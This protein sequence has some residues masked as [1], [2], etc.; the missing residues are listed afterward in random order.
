MILERDGVFYPIEIKAKST[1]SRKD[2]TGISSFR[3]T[4]P[5]LNIENGLVLCPSE[6]IMQL[7]E[8]D[9]AVPWDS[10]GE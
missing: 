2:T 1:P 7:S 9:Y 6:R 3:K 4:Y 10:V 8:L 5:H